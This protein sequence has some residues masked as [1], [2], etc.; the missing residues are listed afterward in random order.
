MPGPIPKPEAQRRRRN[1]PATPVTH[2]A[3][4]G[5][6]VQAPPAVADWHP[7]VV[8]LYESL[9][10]SGQSR[11]YEAS[12][13]ATARLTCHWLSQT[14][15]SGRPSAQVLET[16]MAALTRLLVTEGDR[17]RL[18]MELTRGP[19]S[20]PDEDAADAVVTDLTSRLAR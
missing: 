12:D 16:C 17:R 18:R 10:G 13:W 6:A 15:T 8:D 14:M 7:L 4:G 2:S 11:W 1:K 3:A 19:Q 5:D 20:D 9:A